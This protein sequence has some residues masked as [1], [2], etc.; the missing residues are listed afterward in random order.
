MWI[1]YYASIYLFVFAIR[2][3]SLWN[4]K[5]RLWLSGRRNWKKDISLIS[6]G[7]APRIWFHVSSLGEF[8]QARPVIENLKKLQPQTSI[9]LTFFSPSGYTI[10]KDYEYADVQYLPSDLPGNATFWID[11]MR[12][13]LAVFVK[14]DLWPGF[15]KALDKK[16]IPAILI[17]AHWQPGKLFESWSVP[18]TKFYLKKFQKIFLQRSENVSYFIQQ[19]FE[20]MAVAGDTRIDR[21]LSLPHEADTKIPIALRSL[22]MF[23]LVAGSTW[24]EDEDVICDVVNTS[25]LRVIIAP[26]NIAPSRISD[27]F[28]KLTVPSCKLSEFTKEDEN[29]QVLIVD[30]IGILAY[31]YKLGKVAYVGGGFGGGIH[32][33]LEPM[34]FGKPV[35]FGSRHEKFPEA[36]D[37]VRM[38]SGI[39]IKD[40]ENLRHV[41]KQLSDTTLPE[42]LG[43]ASR[44]YLEEHAGASELVTNYILDSIPFP[45]EL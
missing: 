27:L 33:I 19:G 35:L 18:L 20:N 22:P 12:P 40:T 39:I 17:S 37:L 44:Q 6:S 26:H 2:L 25:E 31:L 11:H 4:E 23:D 28:S 30:S 38:G 29:V 13:D 3:S 14:Y 8:E 15:L 16:N 1:V 24:P 7:D 5:S 36:V 21:S 45:Q 41:L 10:R 32:N 42:R 43:L 34:A 9:I